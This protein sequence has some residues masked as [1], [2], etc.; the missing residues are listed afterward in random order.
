MTTRF[1]FVAYYALFFLAASMLLSNRNE[2][3]G[4]FGLVV[5]FAGTEPNFNSVRS[6]FRLEDFFFSPAQVYYFLL[7]LYLLLLLLYTHDTDLGVW[8]EDIHG[9]TASV[10]T[11]EDVRYTHKQLYPYG[12]GHFPVYQYK[13]KWGESFSNMQKTMK[14][15]KKGSYI[16]VYI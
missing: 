5:A 1:L 12:N 10:N 16:Y 9:S 14:H 15:I 3:G 2:N 6:P 4:N 8:Y 7:T 13:N 11:L